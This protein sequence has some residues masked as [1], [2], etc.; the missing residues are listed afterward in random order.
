M[1]LLEFFYYRSIYLSNVTATENLA[2]SIF[3]VKI[4]KK[5]SAKC[6][7]FSGVL[8]SKTQQVPGLIRNRLTEVGRNNF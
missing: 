6:F 1:P 8:K 2:F 4:F 3:F 5:P 7:I